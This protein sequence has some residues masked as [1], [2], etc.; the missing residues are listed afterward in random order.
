MKK[1]HNYENCG[2][3]HIIDTLINCNDN[4]NSNDNDIKE[5][6]QSNNLSSNS[7][8]NKNNIIK[9]RSESYGKGYQSLPM[10]PIEKLN[11]VGGNRSKSII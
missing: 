5:K 3:F 2:K 4:K 9:K 1:V 11:F 10:I 7:K 6:H 8:I